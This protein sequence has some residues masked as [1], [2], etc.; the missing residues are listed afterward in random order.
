MTVGGVQLTQHVRSSPLRDL[1]Q[2]VCARERQYAD[3]TSRLSLACR[4]G[5][6]AASFHAESARRFAILLDMESHRHAANAHPRIDCK[7]RAV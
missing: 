1:G 2:C 6:S 3:S 4:L 5:T 7:Q